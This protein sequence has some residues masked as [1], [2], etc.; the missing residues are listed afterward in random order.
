MGGRVIACSFL[1]LI[2]CAHG[3]DERHLRYP[4]LIASTDVARGHTRFDIVCGPCHGNHELRRGPPLM[5]QRWTPPR[6]RQRVREGT[7]LM[8]AI[9]RR[10]LSDEDLES[11]LAYFVTV[12]V[13]VERDADEID[14][15]E[16]ASERARASEST[17]DDDDDDDDEPTAAHLLASPYPSR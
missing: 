8:P 6:I 15:S 14:L 13:A 2:G 5:N 9:P 4:G 16:I 7:A 3:P 10:R 11:L 17:S 12:G 1:L